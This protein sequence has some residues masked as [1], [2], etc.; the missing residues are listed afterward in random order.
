MTGGRRLAA[1]AF[2]VV[3]LMSVSWGQGRPTESSFLYVWAGD[4]DRQDTDFLAVLDIRPGPEQYG[5]VV[6]TVPVGENVLYPHHTEQE[7]GPSGMLFANGFAGNRTFLFDLR[8]PLKPSVTTRFGNVGDLDLSFLH[9]FFRLPNGHVVATFQGLGDEN[10]RPGGVA[11]L[12][13]RGRPVRATTAADPAADQGTLRP[14]GVAV[15]PELDRVVIGLT[16]MGF[17]SWRGNT[18]DAWNDR[19]GSQVQVRR[20]SDLTLVKTIKLPNAD[21]PSEPR[22][23]SDGKTVMVL[24]MSCR[25][26]RVAGLE[27]DEPS[28]DL[29]YDPPT[30]GGCGFP[31][32]AG[33]YWLQPNAAT[34]VVSSLDVSD[35]TNVREVSS[36]QFDSL[37]SPHWLAS[38]GQRVVVASQIGGE[39]RLWMM[40]IDP[41]T[42]RLTIDEA[43]R[44]EGSDRPGF[45]FGQDVWP[46]GSTGGALPHGTVFGP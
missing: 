23:L 21:R 36:V 39:G 45:S 19:D 2:F 31:V 22:V 3:V 46:H 18:K 33:N 15:V 44:N 43:F 20:L 28:L 13:E 8:E 11:V 12:D 37:Q 4:E 32:V 30:S 41:D 9:G 27:G 24:T 16:Y 34:R 29:A 7:L 26:Y 14:Y 40:D 5:R 1:V 10:R 35:P 42:G 38:D 17:P 25:V 6:A